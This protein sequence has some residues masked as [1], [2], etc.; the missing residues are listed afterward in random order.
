[1]GPEEIK[2]FLALIEERLLQ[3]QKKGNRPGSAI[4]RSPKKEQKE[5]RKE[6]AERAR[7]RPGSISLK[8][9]KEARQYGEEGAVKTTRPKRS[10][11]PFRKVN[12][13]KR[14]AP[15]NMRKWKL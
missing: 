6:K 8:E 5:R 14:I 2:V 7:A 9:L 11:Y 1:M 13:T 15:S 12:G 3:V 4:L 10:E